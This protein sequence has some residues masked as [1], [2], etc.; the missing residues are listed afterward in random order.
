VLLAVLA[1]ARGKSVGEERL[2]DRIWGDEPPANPTKALQVVVSRARSATA[3]DVIERAGHGY[4]LALDT[5]DVDVWAQ[6]Q[7]VEAARRAASAGAWSEALAYLPHLGAEPALAG[8]ILAAVGRYDDAWPLLATADADAPADDAAFAALLRSEAAVRGVPA[9]LARYEAHRERL[10]D[11]LGVDPAPELQALHQELLLRDRPVRSGLSHYATS[12]VGRDD[13]L[14]RLRAL[15]RTHRVVSILG[16]GGL[17][18]TRL[19]QLVAAEADQPVVHVVEL[20]GVVD[21]A[22]VVAEVGSVLG[23]RDSLTGRRVLTPE[24]Q[25]DVRSRIAQ[26]LDQAPTLL[27]L[28][29]CEHLVDAVADLV[30]F[31]VAVTPTLRVLTT[32]RAPLAIAAEHV[33][34]LS[35]LGASDAAD[36]FRQRALAARPGVALPAAAVREIVERLDGLPLAI[37]LAAVKV[38]A[39]SVDDIATRLENRFALLR[40]G[41]RSAP[42]RHQTLLAVIDWSWNL[43]ADRDRRGLRR[44]SVFHDGL[45]LDAAEQVLGADALAT[46]EELVTQ[47]LLTVIDGGDGMPL[48]YR[49]LETVREFGRMQLIDAGEEDDARRAHRDWAVTVADVLS[50][51]LFTRDQVAT[52]DQVA[53]EENNLA[54]ALRRALAEADADAVVALVATLGGFWSIRGEHPR[55]IMLCEPVAAVLTSVRAAPER[56]DQARAAICLT[57]INSWFSQL[58][59]LEALV[60]ELAALGP[61]TTS[62][63]IAAMTTVVLGASGTTETPML[64]P[65]DALVDDPDPQVRSIALQWR[66]HERENVGD[67]AGAIAAA[68]AALAAGTDE[69]G[70][71][72]RAVLHAQLAGLYSQMG[73]IAEA[74]PH[75]RA[76]VPVLLRLG[77]HDDALEAM[78]VSAIACLERGDPDAAQRV[79]D[80]A[81]ALTDQPPS[82]YSGRGTMLITRAEI[83]FARGEVDDGCRMVEEAA[84][85]MAAI[86]FP[87]MGDDADIAPW[88]IY[89]NTVAVVAL[90]VH[91]REARGRERHP[92]LADA[93]RRVLDREPGFVDVPVVGLMLFALGSWGLTFATMPP[94]D[95]VRLLALA[96]RMSYPRFVPSLSWPR[97]VER[98]EAAAPGE[99]DRLAAEYGER[100]GLDLL[101]ETRG[102]IARLYP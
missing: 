29:N 100:R 72:T 43:L 76:A 15:V 89:G 21:P 24:Q 77:A 9:A 2:I 88:R 70:P 71:W 17:G 91:G 87:G 66:S 84:D 10:A 18:K 6:D 8:R 60:G 96:D 93:A 16:P 53:V 82:G 27:V 49:M 57:L 50:A 98:C 55:V 5:G 79:L 39:M 58:G 86:S 14:G 94:A 95:A 31:L 99:L 4:R 37:E 22:D 35:R 74:E 12:L 48:R 62:R 51:R 7:A 36:L 44:L 23:V 61:G 19:A 63:R 97:A 28:D 46:V 101:A 32:T 102:V 69:D 3:P 85:A 59:A 92:W 90:A 11:R 64:S 13:D 25:R 41:D 81:L 34:E 54:D 56:A 65:T 20:V 45:T 83:A 75:A 80:E 26:Q 47:S 52:V 33:F 1:D 73:R 30:A 38:R 67:A 42:D 78:T 68:E 40:G